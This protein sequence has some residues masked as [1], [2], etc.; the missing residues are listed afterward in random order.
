MTEKTN[1]VRDPIFEA[2]RR[3]R[4][5]YFHPEGQLNQE[6]RALIMQKAQVLTDDEKTDDE[7]RG[8]LCVL[9]FI[10]REKIQ[11]AQVDID[12]LEREL[13]ELDIATLAEM[14]A[15]RFADDVVPCRS[16]SNLDGMW[17]LTPMGEMLL[18]R[19]REV[20]DNSQH[21]WDALRTDDIPV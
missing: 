15:V 10:L 19:L 1:D 11:K 18:Y 5:Q 3:N 21:M 16:F 9:L 8:E 14:G 4:G 12:V 2:L 17:V 13:W 7:K 6:Q 20:H